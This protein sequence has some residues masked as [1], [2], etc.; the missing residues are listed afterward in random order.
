MSVRI[1]STLA[2][3][4]L[5]SA[6]SAFAFNLGDAANAVSGM[7]GGGNEAGEQSTTAVGKQQADFDR[8]PEQALEFEKGVC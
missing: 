6:S 4:A 7:A 2:A 8:L 5:L 3:L 1:R